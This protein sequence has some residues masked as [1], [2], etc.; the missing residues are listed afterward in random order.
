[1]I[2]HRLPDTGDEAVVDLYHI[3]GVVAQAGQRRVARAEVIH[4]QVYAERLDPL[5]LVQRA[6]CFP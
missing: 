6:L 1:M 3:E 2:F 4:G 5:E